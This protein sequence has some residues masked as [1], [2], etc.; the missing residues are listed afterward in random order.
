[1]GEVVRI[2]ALGSMKNVPVSGAIWTGFSGG[3]QRGG[4][5]GTRMVG[6]SLSSQL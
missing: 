6:S 1:M 5:P 3:S 2:P 4:A